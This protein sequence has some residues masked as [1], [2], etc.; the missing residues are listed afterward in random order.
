MRIM[1][2]GGDGYLGWPTAI[3]LSRR[4]HEVAVVDN[5]ARRAWD[6]EFGAESLIPLASLQERIQTWE[7]LTGKR[8]AAYVGDLTD[9]T[10]LEPAVREF[11][12]EAIVH[13][14]EQRAAPYSMID[15]RHAVFTQV[16]NIV[17]TLNVLYAMTDRIVFFNAPS[18]FAANP[19]PPGTRLR[20]GGLGGGGWL[21]ARG[22]GFLSSSARGGV[23]VAPLTRISPFK[24]LAP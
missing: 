22:G 13:Y 7:T 3:Y 23:P 20:L 11:R 9:Y 8:I 19:S 21:A 18:D 4:G 2:L 16:N 12:P 15:R 1:V 14:G 6:Y 5:M 17:G 24:S 10:F